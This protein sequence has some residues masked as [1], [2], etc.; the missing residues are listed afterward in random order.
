MAFW[1]EKK[2]I[3]EPVR[4]F[5]FTIQESG[6]NQT[7]EGSPSDLGI[8]WWAKSVSKPSFEIS[9]EEYLLINHK[10]KFPGVATWSDVNLK[11]IDYKDQM[12]IEITR[13]RSEIYDILTHLTFLFIESHKIQ[14]RVSI[15][16]GEDFTREWLH[17]EDV[18]LHQKEISEEEK[19]VII[20]EL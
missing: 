13:G 8:W 3:I 5:R 11:M 18:V 19:E 1:S 15:N 12:N 9:Q 6:V 14:E 2:D 17:L 10:I 20:E 4:P 7:A 16:E